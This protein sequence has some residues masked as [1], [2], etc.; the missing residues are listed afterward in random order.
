MENGISKQL[1]LAF[2]DFERSLSE[3]KTLE[4]VLEKGQR[5]E[6]MVEELTIPSF[7]S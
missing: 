7:L 3:I 2:K 6:R 1:A 4:L 5:M